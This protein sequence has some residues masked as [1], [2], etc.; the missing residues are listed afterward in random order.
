MRPFEEFMS[1]KNKYFAALALVSVLI[2]AA[3]A[4]NGI[5]YWGWFL[6]VGV[7]FA[8]EAGR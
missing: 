4:W 2:A 1:T 5:P 8:G 7:L 6:V 3:G